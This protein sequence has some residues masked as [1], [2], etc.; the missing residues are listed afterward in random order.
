M[1]RYAHTPFLGAYSEQDRR[2]AFVA[3]ARSGAAHLAARPADRLSGGELQRVLLARCLAQETDLLL[4]DEATAG[5]DPSCRIQV[6]DAL[7]RRVRE[8]G[9]TVLAAMH[10]L[11]LAALY[12]G[13]L[14]LLNEGRIMADGPTDEIFTQD[15]L[16]RVFGPE[17][18]VTRHPTLN[19]PQ[20]LF[21]PSAAS[22]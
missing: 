22:A 6:L 5:L 20:A 21:L 19:R 11:N 18:L 10:D 4:L 7:G 9:I 14:I 17:I 8:N 3:L 12:C 2:M 13:R 16:G 15:V 1:G